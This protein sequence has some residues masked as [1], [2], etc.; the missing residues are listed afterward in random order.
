MKPAEFHLIDM[1]TWPRRE[2][3]EYYKNL[4]KTSYNLTANVDI[5]R[6]LFRCN[7]TK[8]RFYPTFVYAITKAVNEIKELRMALDK[9]GNLGWYDYLNPSYT[10]FH[11]DDETFSDVWSPWEEDFKTFYD[12]MIQDM[13]TFKDV[14]GI[15]AKPD[16]PDHFLPVSNSPWTT[17]TGY[18]CDTFQPSPLLF[19]VITFGR[20]FSNKVMPDC[21]GRS[22]S[23]THTDGPVSDYGIRFLVPVNIFVPHMVADGYHVG[24]FFSE[25]QDLCDTAAKW[26][27]APP[28]QKKGWFR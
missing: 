4:V 14:K 2:H 20:Y 13:E 9:D 25:L 19:P 15:K 1:E 18:A 7:E 24:K 11:K 3:Y 27:P 21:L 26:I 12:G 22:M 23:L 5:S 16:K 8:Q 28:P 6:L 10:I 17:F